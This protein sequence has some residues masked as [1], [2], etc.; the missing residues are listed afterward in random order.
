MLLCSFFVL[1]F[2]KR[3]FYVGISTKFLFKLQPDWSKQ[4]PVLFSFKL[5]LL[6]FIS[7]PVNANKNLLYSLYG[8]FLFPWQ[9]A[10]I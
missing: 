4:Q 9:Q 2:S 7:A 8:I 3:R 6:H 10:R 1:F 5:N